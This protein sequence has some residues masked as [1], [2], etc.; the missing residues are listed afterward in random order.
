MSSELNK[1]YFQ[2]KTDLKIISY[3]INKPAIFDNY[4]NLC[5]KIKQT[6]KKV[7]EFTKELEI[8][9]NYIKEILC[10]NKQDSCDFLLKWL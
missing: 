4:L 8:I 7:D 3:D 2:D 9:L 6:H 5:P 1:Y 10:S